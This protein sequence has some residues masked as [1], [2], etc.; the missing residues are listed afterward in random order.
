VTVDG[1]KTCVSSVQDSNGKD[2][3]LGG[4]FLRNVYSVWNAENKTVSL[5][6]K[7]RMS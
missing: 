7:K 2:W 6:K 1:G 5:A 4:A 3:I